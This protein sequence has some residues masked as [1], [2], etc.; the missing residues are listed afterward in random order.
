[1]PTITNSV[2]NDIMNHI[3]LE[4]IIS[5]YQRAGTEWS[6][7]RFTSPH[8]SK[9]YFIIGGDAYISYG[10]KRRYLLPGHAYLIPT[11]LIYD[12]G[13]DSRIDFLYFNIRLTNKSGY[14]FLA[15]YPEMLECSYPVE[16]TQR[17]VELY[18]SPELID[19]LTLRNN[20]L[21]CVLNM[22]TDYT[23][24]K[25]SNKKYSRCVSDALN[26]ICGNL[27]IRLSVE[28]ICRNVYAARSTLN[29][30]FSEEVGTPIGT[31]IDDEV[32]SRCEQLLIDTDLSIRQISE[33]FGFCD[34]FYFSRRFKAKYGVT[35]QKYRNLRVI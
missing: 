7:V 20:L 15:S 16:E 13:C 4:I 2:C 11:D 25:L 18:R 29:K 17:L 23:A 14:D 12:N 28:E 1:M 31:Y 27:S 19:S 32:M 24:V 10:G 26:Y 30:K 8:Y 6:K 9:L 3:T 35:P 34:Q 33:K 22:M 21:T 5:G